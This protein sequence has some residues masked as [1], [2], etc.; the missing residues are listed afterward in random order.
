[1]TPAGVGKLPAGDSKTAFQ[2][3]FRCASCRDLLA[4]IVQGAKETTQQNHSRPNFLGLIF[5]VA[6]FCKS[7]IC[8]RRKAN[9]TS[10]AAS[11]YGTDLLGDEP[12]P[13]T[14]KC[15]PFRN[16]S[17]LQTL[18]FSQ[19]NVRPATVTEHSF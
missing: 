10:H 17:A 6:P 18:G 5:Q 16:S 13:Q 9:S 2:I 14:N 11:L 3:S 7:M 12:L 8:E 19:T 15:P 1:M 4:N